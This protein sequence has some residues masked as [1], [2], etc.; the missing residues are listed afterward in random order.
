ML[1]SL[2]GDVLYRDFPT[3]LVVQVYWTRVLFYT[4]VDRNGQQ[5][6]EVSGS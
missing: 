5:A 6:T 3:P 1:T 2:Y 4:S